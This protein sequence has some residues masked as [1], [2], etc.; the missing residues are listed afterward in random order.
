MEVWRDIP[1]YEG[2]Y[3]ASTRGRI[4]GLDRQVCDPQGKCRSHKGAIKMPQLHNTG[5]LVVHLYRTTIREKKFIHRIVAQTFLENPD[6]HPIV[7]HIDRDRKNNTIE[8]LE[9]IDA[10][11]NQNHW[12]QDEKARADALVPPIVVNDYVFTDGD[13]PF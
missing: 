5:Y 10:S 9:W 6:D 1:G 13:L 8:N 2:H 7:N 4:R 11:G 12:R 3:Q